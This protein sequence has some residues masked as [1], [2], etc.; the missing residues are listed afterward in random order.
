MYRMYG[1]PKMQE[2]FLGGQD[3]RYSETGISRRQQFGVSPDERQSL[4]EWQMQEQF[5]RGPDTAIARHFSPHIVIVR[6]LLLQSLAGPSGY[7][8]TQS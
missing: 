3:V 2:Q 4:C 6:Q 8:R 5:L 1:T 7:F